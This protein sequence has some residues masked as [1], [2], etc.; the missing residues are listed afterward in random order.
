MNEEVASREGLAPRSR[1][2]RLLLGTLFCLSVADGILTR[3]IISN[4]LG[5]EGNFW[6]SDLASSDALIGI[7]M[8]GTALAIYLLWRLHYV[9]PKL[10]MATTVAFVGWYTLVVFWNIIVIVIGSK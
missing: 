1:T 10:V 6:L 5:H 2:Q 9:R 4:G 8:L 7:K 3:F